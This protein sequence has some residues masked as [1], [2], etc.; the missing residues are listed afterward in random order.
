[1]PQLAGK[2][3][4]FNILFIFWELF[5]IVFFGVH[6]FSENKDTLYHKKA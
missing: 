3:V 2:L 5:I 6:T 4:L 1:M